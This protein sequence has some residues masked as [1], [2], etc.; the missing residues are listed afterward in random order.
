MELHPESR[1]PIAKTIEHSFSLHN[2]TITDDYSWMRWIDNDSDV[3]AYIQ[4]ENAFADYK[5][6]KY[7]DLQ[8]II[9]NELNSWTL[10]SVANTKVV[11]SQLCDP[12]AVDRRNFWEHGS[13]MYWTFQPEEMKHS[14]YMRQASFPDKCGCVKYIDGE[15]EQV[16]LDLNTVV[17]SN[18][19]YAQIG[20]FEISLYDEDL[21]AF[22][23]DLRGSENFRIFIK[24]IRTG[25]NLGP[26]EGIEGTYYSGRWAVETVLGVKRHWF[27]YNVLHPT[28][29]VPSLIYRVCVVGCNSKME[30]LS[31]I[32]EADELV[33]E[34]KEEWVYSEQDPSLT[35]ELESDYGGCSV[36]LKING[37]DL[38]ES[39]LIAFNGVLNEYFQPV[40]KREKGVLYD[41]VFS[42]DFAFIRTNAMGALEFQIVQVDVAE[43]LKP[44]S[45]ELILTNPHKVLLHHEPGRFIEKMEVFAS[46]LVAWVWKRGFR[47]FIV[48][49]LETAGTT[50]SLPPPASVPY[51]IF[52]AT[53]DDMET[54]LFRRYM[55]TCFTFSNSSM[56]N[57][58]QVHSYDMVSAATTLLI[59]DF[60]LD[61]DSERY[62]EFVEWVLP[63]PGRLQPIPIYV[64][65]S[66]KHPNSHRLLLRAYGAYGGFQEAKFSTDIFSLIDRGFSYAICHPRGDSDM[67]R[68]WYL[69]GKLTKKKNTF[70]DTLEC[71]EHLIKKGYTSA[72]SVAV[73]GRSAGGLIAGTAIN[74]WS[75][76]D[77]ARN[78]KNAFVR[79]VVA[80]VPFVDPINDMIDISVPWTAYEWSEWGDPRESRDIFEAMMDYSP[81]MNIKNNSFF[82]HIYISGGF[83]VSTNGSSNWTKMDLAQLTRRSFW[84]CRRLPAARL[85]SV[86]DGDGTGD[87][88][89]KEF[90]SGLSAFSSKGNKEEKLRFAFKVYDMDRD[91][92]ISN[93]ELF[94]VLKMMVGNNLRD[95]Q[96]QQIVDK[97]I[98]EAD[99]DMDGKI[100][101][102]E[103]SKV[104]ENTDIARQMTLE[105]DRF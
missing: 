69:E 1:P 72:G 64:L 49:S 85:L 5:M 19:T 23:L 50:F 73:L 56:K 75:W 9:L 89:F 99:L 59:Q 100:S 57:P 82:P 51:S 79:A 32:D 47:H 24:N 11:N 86:L 40:F 36:V 91:G 58:V 55:T 54:R 76:F 14:V 84:R 95:N 77:R 98:M 103:F 81:Y 66:R 7:A 18:A 74:H 4:A 71:I 70:T 67:G 78:N 20:I 37:L 21:L 30:R 22:S 96:L 93:G 10:K 65:R 2:V 12:L 39:R 62:E 38:S 60:F 15:D 6:A 44:N 16:V 43:A 80:Q 25:E 17:P 90:I 63:H 45:L 104:V 48:I 8:S 94:L 102:D 52:P 61:F 68:A 88:D 87:V 26:P 97:T 53:N 31:V 27:Y 105:N 41:I 29:R 3:M 13:F 92:F 101:F 83:N 28:L 35:T 42:L 34:S 46:H 33:I